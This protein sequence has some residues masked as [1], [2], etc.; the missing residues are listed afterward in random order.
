MAQD[1]AWRVYSTSASG[2]AK[3]RHT[4]VPGMCQGFS[5]GRGRSFFREAL[6]PPALAIV[7]R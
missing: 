1:C 5:E 2:I 7:C 3:T 4:K 6:E